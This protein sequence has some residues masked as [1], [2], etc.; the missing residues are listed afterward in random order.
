MWE[1]SNGEEITDK[2]MQEIIQKAKENGQTIYSSPDGSRI[3]IRAL[4][5]SAW[6][7]KEGDKWVTHWAE[8]N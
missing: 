8:G 2:E 4:E 6:I 5:P 7:E 1:L 3:G